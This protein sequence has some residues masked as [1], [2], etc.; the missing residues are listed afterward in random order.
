MTATVPSSLALAF[1]TVVALTVWLFLRAV[2]NPRRAT[3][4]LALWFALQGMFSLA[5]FY[6]MAGAGAGAPPRLAL[7]VAPPAL[8]IVALLATRGGRAWLDGLRLD[9]LTLM[10][11]IRVAVELILLGLYRHGAVPK[12]MTFEG[13]NWD[14]FS[15]VSA[16]VVW[17]LAFRT[18]RMGR[19]ALLAWNVVCLALVLKV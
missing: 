8:A 4:V 3:I 7:A 15:G 16:P 13:A 1:V 6:A 18:R 12:L 11:T 2:P 5:G 9:R 10:H 17:W 19:H 14:L